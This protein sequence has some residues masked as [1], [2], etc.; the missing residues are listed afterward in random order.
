MAQNTKVTPADVESKSTS[1]SSGPAKNIG[2][3]S[4]QGT[5]HVNDAVI[6]KIAGLALRDVEGV[7][8]LG[9]G[10]AR[11]L[12]AIRSFAGQ[13]ENL[14]QGVSVEVGQTQAAVDLSLVVEYPY[15]LYKVA[16]DAR[17]SVIK[18]I[19]DLAGLEVT[20]VNIEILDVHVASED[21]EEEVEEE[22]KTESRVK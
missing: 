6:A 11:A 21:D 16:E 10:A 1:A 20:E 9:G 2:A 3:D 8:A 14:K 15:P 18:A 5:T 12:G 7:Y 22:T 13:E 17:N 19:E 4:G